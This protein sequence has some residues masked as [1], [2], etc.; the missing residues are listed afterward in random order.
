MPLS[1]S[2]ETYM[3]ATEHSPASVVITD[4]SGTILYVNEKFAQTTGYTRDEAIGKNPR[5]L[6]SGIQNDEFYK[7]LWNTISNGQTWQGDFHN[8]K[9]NG[10]VYWELASIS[11]VVNSIGEITHYVAV[12]EDITERK[13]MEIELMKSSEQAEAANKAKSEFIANMSHEIRTP[14]NVIMGFSTILQSRLSEFPEYQDYCLGIYNSGKNLLNLINDI[15]DLSKI[16]A[17]KFEISPR[18]LNFPAF[19]KDVVSMF[20]IK[21]AEKGIDLTME[22]D[23]LGCQH[24]ML[25]EVRLRQILFNLIGNAI[26]FTDHGFVHIQC[27]AKSNKASSKL[28][29]EIEVSDSGIG[30]PAKQLKSIFLPFTQLENVN[31]KKYEG[32]GLGLSIS[33]RLLELMGGSIEA[34]SEEEK[35]SVFKIKIPDIPI[36]AMADERSPKTTNYKFEPARILI[37]ED[38]ASNRLVIKGFLEESNLEIYECENAQSAIQLLPKINPNL[39]LLDIQMPIMNGYEFIQKVKGMDMFRK[40]PILVISASAMKEDIEYIKS[41]CDG[42]LRKP[43][44]RTELISSIAKHLNHTTIK[45]EGQ[46]SVEEKN[47]LL[48]A[49]KNEPGLLIEIT[50]GAIGQSFAKA[51]N[52]MSITQIKAFANLL[53]EEGRKLKLPALTEFAENLFSD[54]ICFNFDRLAANMQT[55]QV[56]T[57]QLN[58]IATDE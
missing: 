24:L 14:M 41:I 6:K 3:I 39:I 21:A 15:L 17:G 31:Q 7:N 20:N 55:F 44:T 50:K 10:D 40:I 47:D 49:V 45:E 16:E 29:L 19:I 58:G 13:N 57:D 26:K 8:R 38:I 48:M 22:T 5:I 27:K 43:V 46:S 18:P 36:A 32:T 9:K 56:L 25:D 35:G 28:T 52:S 54:A 53:K 30:I 34:S 51:N 42:Y 12:K 37:I 4:R 1:F 11:P 33:K 23:P 2:P